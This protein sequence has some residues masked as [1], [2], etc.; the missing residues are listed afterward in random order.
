MNKLIIG[1]GLLGSELKKQSGWDY[2][3]RKKDDIDF[4]DIN[5]YKDYLVGYDEIINCVVFSDT[6]SEN[7][8]LHWNI[9]YKGVVELVDYLFDKNIK[10][11]HVSTDYLYSNSK[12]NVSEDDV[13]VHCATWYGYTKLLSDAY[14]QLKLD[15]YLI[16]RGTHKKRP[17][18]YDEGL[19]NQIGNFEYVDEIEQQYKNQLVK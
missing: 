8:E 9:N 3:S 15:N 18:I 10:L 12:S 7:K 19:V 11:I 16:F 5:S 4:A 14:V 6:Y 17:F 13:P 1:D 2:I